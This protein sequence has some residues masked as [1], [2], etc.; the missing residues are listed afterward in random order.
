MKRIIGPDLE[1]HIVEL[2]LYYKNV[3]AS[4]RGSDIGLGF[5]AAAHVGCR[6]MGSG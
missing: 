2:K 4:A 6:L 5:R 1:A 3:R